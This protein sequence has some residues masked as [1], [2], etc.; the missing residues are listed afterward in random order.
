MI[1]TERPTPPPESTSTEEAVKCVKDLSESIYIKTER[2]F[3]R[4]RKAKL[5]IFLHVVNTTNELTLSFHRQDHQSI[6]LRAQV[7]LNKCRPK[8]T[9]NERQKKRKTLKGTATTVFFIHDT[10]CS[11]LFLQIC[12]FLH[13]SFI[14]LLQSSQFILYFTQSGA[15]LV[16][17][18]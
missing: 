13:I 11:Y 17:T 4:G 15:F 2:S 1:S 8:N 18:L 12:F 7:S 6:F 10:K 5:T 16:Q 9:N 14:L 3:V